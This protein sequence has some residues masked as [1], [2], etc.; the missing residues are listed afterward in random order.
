MKVHYQLEKDRA[1]IVLDDGKANTMDLPFFETL[2]GALDRAEEDGAK[3][4][5]LTG[6]EKFFS[7]GLNLGIVTSLSREELGPFVRAFGNAMLR[8]WTCPIPTVAACTGH[9]V[10]GGAILAFA[11]DRRIL[12]DGP[13]KVQMN[14]SRNKMMLP[15]WAIEIC[16]SAIPP[17]HWNRALLHADA[18]TPS[19][20]VSLGFFEEATSGPVLARGREIAE[21]YRGIDL[22]SYAVTKQRM[23]GA[24]DKR[25]RALFEKEH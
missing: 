22:R 9:A 8:V 24:A 6:R 7:A 14:E 1:E 2:C 15:S 5:L 4:V 13:F 25:L 11:C 19:E 16:Q 21:S 17:S 12:L 23:R 3:S 18:Y 20:A 10:A